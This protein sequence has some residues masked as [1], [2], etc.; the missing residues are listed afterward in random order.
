MASVANFVVYNTQ[1][2]YDSLDEKSVDT[3]YYIQ[4]TRRIY[5]GEDLY[6]DIISVT[7]LP[8][9]DIIPF[10]FYLVNDEEIYF[11]A[12]NSWIQ[13]S[14]TE[15]DPSQTID[16]DGITLNDKTIGGIKFVIEES[17]VLKI[18]ENWQYN[19]RNSL[20][21]LG[22]IHNNGILNIE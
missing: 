16:A 2:G 12:S 14:S 22:T 9:E 21:L 15:P 5:Q 4:E 20:T 8:L 17:D 7:E 3:F 1:A 6:N 10:K 19:V 11:R 13:I 18:P